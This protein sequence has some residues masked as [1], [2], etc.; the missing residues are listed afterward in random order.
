MLTSMG[1]AEPFDRIPPGGGF[2]FERHGLE[3]FLCLKVA[4]DAEQG[5]VA[6][7]LTGLG[8]HFPE[9]LRAAFEGNV[10]SIPGLRLV[11][12]PFT[13]DISMNMAVDYN[14]GEICLFDNEEAFLVF[15]YRQH[16]SLECDFLFN[17]KSAEIALSNELVMRATP[18]VIKRWAFVIELFN[19]P[20]TLF[21]YPTVAEKLNF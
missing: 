19:K 3:K 13:D 20:L 9:F 6:V 8:S 15:R 1:S 16:G 21:S 14:P 17:L 4:T 12:S 7:P 18:I 5:A 2:L 11:T 10:L